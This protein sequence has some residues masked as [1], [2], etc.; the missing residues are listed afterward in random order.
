MH[1]VYKLLVVLLL[2]YDKKKLP[3]LSHTVLKKH[4][5]H[6]EKSQK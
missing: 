6:G 5:V 4:I 3:V 2:S 1:A